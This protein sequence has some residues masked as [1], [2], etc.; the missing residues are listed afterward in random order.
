MSDNTSGLLSA[1]STSDRATVTMP[2]TL[3]MDD[4]DTLNR[5]VSQA[6]GICDAV[7][8]SSDLGEQH[9]SALWAAVNLLPLR[10]GILQRHALASCHGR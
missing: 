3:P 6:L 2:V 8:A 7:Q 5:V 10:R 1:A 9:A 4:F